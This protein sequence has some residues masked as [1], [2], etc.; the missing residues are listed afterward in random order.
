MPRA[1][2]PKRVREYKK[3]EEELEKQGGCKGREKEVAARIVNKERAK[4]GET[5][6]WRQRKRKDSWVNGAV[7]TGQGKDIPWAQFF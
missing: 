5:K 2:S 1:A 6:K 3:I 7:D 4:V